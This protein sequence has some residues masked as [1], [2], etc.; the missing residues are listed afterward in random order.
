MEKQ[1]ENAGII[2]DEKG[3][4]VPGQSGNPAGKPKGTFS[5]TALI[6]QKLQDCPEGEKKTYAEYVIDRIMKDTLKGDSRTLKLLWNYIDGMPKQNISFEDTT[7]DLEILKKALYA[8]GKTKQHIQDER[9]A[10]SVKSDTATDIQ[11]NID[12]KSSES[13]GDTT[14]PVR[15][16]NDSSVG[17]IA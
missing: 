13:T 4:F 3:Q 6:K 16:V 14:D 9:K 8:T 7:D 10:D 1:P 11:D 2:R 17:G 15:E 5:I 12:P